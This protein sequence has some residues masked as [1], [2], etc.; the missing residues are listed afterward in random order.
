MTLRLKLVVALASLAILATIAIG[1]TSYQTT[2]VQLEEEIDRSLRQARDQIE[3]LIE[4]RP[5]VTILL[6]S[7]PSDP[8]SRPRDFDRIIVQAFG[9]DGAV[10]AR[11]TDTAVPIDEVDRSIAAGSRPEQ[12]RT[13]EVDDELFRV[14][15]TPYG[16]G[17]AVQY[18]R[19]MEETHRVLDTIRVRTL[20][21]VGLIGAL[22]TIGGWLIANR[23]TR[24]LERLTRTAE[25]V[26][27]T[28]RLDVPT[29]EAGV[30]EVGR[31]GGAFAAMLAA[32]RRSRDAQTQLVQDA[33]HELRTPLTSLRTNI[34]LLRRF[35]ELP[36]DVREQVVADLDSEARELSVLVDEIIG[37]AIDQPR[38]EPEGPVDLAALVAGA[39]D[40]TERRTGRRITVEL[41]TAA[42][43]RDDGPPATI[44][45]RAASIER[46]VTNLLDNAT[47][48]SDD[49]TPIEVRVDGGRIE[50]SDRGIG[51][52]AADLH[53]VFDR[54]Y[55][56][57]EAR[58]RPG[59]GLGLA[60]V[61]S[62]ADD[63]GG[64]TE[65]TPR[66]GGGTTIALVLP[67]DAERG[68]LPR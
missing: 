5:Q 40:R 53:R 23:A 62:V 13:I 50:V 64:R 3:A 17:V 30:D 52:P 26:A 65:V 46:A 63:H 7:L 27:S 2:S 11:S 29:P 54:F 6:E 16:N 56:T 9:A 31:L 39:V 8:T 59:S 42:E 58:S 28:G 48:F 22:A 32:L 57:V 47:K 15:T 45:G 1:V 60:I 67:T 44:T 33:G 68:T 36:D 18:A 55:R 49:A 19:S 35:D 61:Q 21:S 10:L 41:A 24:R 43:R 14:M 37:L 4:G 12:T 38:D 51:I 20:V 66:A 25:V 34:A